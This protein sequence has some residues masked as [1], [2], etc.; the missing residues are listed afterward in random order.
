MECKYNAMDLILDVL[1]KRGETAADIKALAV[2]F[3]PDEDERYEFADY[4][5]ARKVLITKLSE[6]LFY[7]EYD[8]PNVTIW[9]LRSVVVKCT[10]EGSAW[11]Q[12]IPRHPE[13]TQPESFGG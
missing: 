7:K 1:E 13:H 9:T 4:E 2:Q 8:S 5:E 3:D 10:Y 11:Y 12:A 6:T